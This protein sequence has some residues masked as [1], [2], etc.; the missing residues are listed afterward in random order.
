[1]S[2]LVKAKQNF[3]FFVVPSCLREEGCASKVSHA[4]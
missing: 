2:L 3:V 1:M 4:D